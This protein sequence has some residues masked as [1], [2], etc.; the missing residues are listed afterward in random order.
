MKKPYFKHKFPKQTRPCYIIG[1]S[2]KLKAFLL[3]H[4][5]IQLEVCTGQILIPPRCIGGRKFLFLAF[6][7]QFPKLCGSLLA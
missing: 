3:C 1:V 6:S 7:L 4:C 5:G 2:P